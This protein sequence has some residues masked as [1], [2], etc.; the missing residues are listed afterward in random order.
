MKTTITRLPTLPAAALAAATLF[1]AWGGGC[2]D[3]TAYVYTGQ[4]FDET[5][6]CVE[7]Y[8]PIDRV[9]GDRTS[10][11]CPPLCVRIKDTLFLSNVCPPFPGGAELLEPDDP[12]CG[13]A[14]AAPS[15]DAE[16]DGGDDA[17]PEDEDAATEE[18]D[19]G[20]EEEDAAT[21]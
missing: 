8:A 16:P 12:T 11:T 5:L 21:D 7:A 9:E 10:S 18:E 13:A 14:L 17:A 4:R 1:V 15:C 19:A 3:S 2:D 6:G 20:T